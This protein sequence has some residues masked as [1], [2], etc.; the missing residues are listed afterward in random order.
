[1]LET[2]LGGRYRIVETLG[3]GGFGQTYL[4]EDAQQPTEFRC[5]IKQ[6]KPINR[7][8]EFLEVARRLF[9][10]EVEILKKLGQHDQIPQFLDF[11][12]ENQEFYLVQEFVEGRSLVDELAQSRLTEAQVLRLLQDVLEVLEFVHRHRVIHR[13]VK[14]GNLIRRDRDQKFVLIDFGAVKEIHTQLAH[15]SG[16]TNITVGI[17]TQGY[18]PSEQLAG[19]P[20]FCSDLYALAMTAIQA[21]TGRQPSQLP[22]DLETSEVLWQP[23]AALSPGLELIL[24]RMVRYHFSQRYQSASEVMQA[25]QL[26]S[27]LPSDQTELPPS[28]VS[29]LAQDAAQDAAQD[30][31]PQSKVQAKLEVWRRS[32]RQRLRSGAIAALAVSSLVL[33]VRQLGG[34]ES[35]E[36][37][38][39]DQMVR[40]RPG[41]EADPR[42]LVVA[43]T[44]A[45]LQALQRP[46]PSDQDVAQ[47]IAKLRQ[48]QPRVI[49]LDLH[50]DLPQE[51]GQ[52]ELLAQLQSAEVVSIMK[53]GSTAETQ[54]PPPPNLPAE[55]VGFSDLPIDPD[56]VVRRSLMFASTEEEVFYSFSLQVA[57]KYL[58]AEGVLPQN[59][60]HPPDAM[61]LA[62]TVF[63]P[64]SETSGGYQQADAA[65]YQIFLNYRNSDQV[66]QQVTFTEVMQ[67]QVDPD[68]VRDR[69]VLIG[70]T[71]PSAKDLF[72][73]PYSAAKAT[74]HQM[75]GVVIHAQ[76]VSQLLSAVLD[77][78]PL[79]WFWSD[80]GEGL[81]IVGWAIAGG[82][83]ATLL[84]HPVVLVL[85]AATG[86][87]L[88]LGCS[89]L[90]FLQQ[91]WVPVVAPAIALLGTG[92]AVVTYRS[93]RVQRQQQAISRYLL[94]NPT[95]QTTS[96]NDFWE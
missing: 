91:G 6:F 18:T 72:Y 21:L 78:R 49:G 43:I 69:I 37:A 60:T 73:T 22:E 48:A 36:L 82:M 23:Y 5:V 51:P 1:M 9:D 46:T 4:A 86:V 47:V 88:L 28:Q 59:A 24:S 39:Y 67:G 61:Q 38:A 20:R 81:W 76:M 35:L 29:P 85:G 33:G 89:F 62:N 40:S 77:E 54:I 93:Y 58:E 84:R 92:A 11:F 94:P 8:R 74:N 31:Q 64:I 32:L 10:Q 30:V 12:E 42:L 25:L 87:G 2:L 66:A 15:R 57:L 68:W 3:A 55:Q 16:E 7:D 50:R 13:D 71:A 41:L 19:K 52:A 34:L 70:T 96:T 45:D 83:A 53:L 65:G 75:S 56:G 90:L 95:D 14:P 17:G 80:G 27:R 63:L 26:L 44:E 79:F